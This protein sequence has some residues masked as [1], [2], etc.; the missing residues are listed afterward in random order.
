MNNHVSIYSTLLPDDKKGRPF[1]TSRLAITFKIGRS[2][3][4]Q[5][6]TLNDQIK[7]RDADLTA[8]R[9]KLNAAQAALADCTIKPLRSL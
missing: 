5:I 4:A 9:E 1:N 3:T 6:N 8:M 2:L 7:Q